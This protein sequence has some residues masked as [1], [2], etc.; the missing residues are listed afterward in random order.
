MQRTKS[1]LR[2]N[3]FLSIKKEWAAFSRSSEFRMFRPAHSAGQMQRFW[4]VLMQQPITNEELMHR[5]PD[6]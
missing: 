1:S 3:R 2:F 4:A 5:E 6:N